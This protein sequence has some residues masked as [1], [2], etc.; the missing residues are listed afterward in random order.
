MAVSKPQSR[1]A[2]FIPDDRQRDAIEHVHGPML[3]VAGA[4]TGKT[5][6]LTNRIAYLVGE[7]H[8][9][10]DEILALTYTKNAA[11]EMRDRVRKLLGGRA[12][13]AATFHDYCLDVLQRSHQ[14]F[15]VLDD[16]DLWIY[17]RRRIRELHLEY[18]VRAANVGQ[19]LTDLLDFVSRCH[20]E[21]VSPDKYSQYV[22]RLERGEVPIPR[23]AKSKNELDDAEVLGRCREIARVFATMERWLEEENLGTFSH[24][25]T[26]AHALLHSDRKGLAE[27]RARARF[28]LVDEF[29]DAN[30]AQIKILARLAG[31]EGNIF[32]VGDPDQA[33]YRFRGA[34]SAAFELF[35]RHFPSSRLVVLEKNRR[36]TTPILRSAFALIDKNPP[37]FA[38]HA[39]GALAYRRTPLQSAREEEAA[40][41][42]NQIS[43]LPVSVVVLTN[44]DAE[45]PDL[46][47]FIRDSK[48]KL[49][50]RWSDFGILY[51]SHFHRDDIVRELAE[52]DIPFV[53]ENMDI[54]D[55]PEARDLLAC[56]IAAVSP[57][58]DV[59]LVRVTALPCF[60]VDPEQLRAV[61]RAIARESREAQV[62]PLASALD[63]LDGGAAVLAALQQTRDEIRR[64]EAK[65][66]A[67]LDIIVR[68]FE[69]NAASPVLQAVLKFVEV[70]EQKKSNRTTSLDELVDY[71]G[72]FREA[73]GVIPL[74]SGAD[75]D[76][77]RLM[78]VHLAKGLE[79]PHVFI[80]R[81]NANS[82]PCGYKETLVG[83]PNELR[84][85]D[86]AAEGDDKTLHNQEERRLFYVAMTRACDSLNIYARQG[87]GKIN[88]NPDGFLRELI[89]DRSL[90]P[91]LKAIP[92]RGAQA[93]LSIFAAVTPSYP[94]ESRTT[95]WLELPVLDGLQSR[96]SASAV[97]TYERCG[98]QFKLERDWRLS[99]KPAA[100]MQYGASMHRVLRTYFDSV[101][102]GR[103]K[104]DEE[105]I[106][107]FRQDL[108]GTRIQEA[109][110]H[111]LYEKQGV[112]QLR[113]LLAS[114]RSQT[115]LQVL[116]TEE[117]FEIRVGETT[118][119]GRFDRIDARP[120]GTVAIVD[121]KTGKAR[122]QENADESLQLS[123]YAIAAREKWG[124]KVGSLIFYNL[125]ENI[126]VFSTR[127]D[128]QLMVARERVEKAAKG[129]AAGEFEP[130]LGI[131]CTFCSYRSLCPAK[132][133]RI[134]NRAVS[135]ALQS[136]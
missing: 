56:L 81:A 17:L 111:E 122:D 134:P 8:A 57:G 27:A 18:F 114:V 107:L 48:K 4:G 129:I 73:G 15:G 126:P 45:G 69:L 82:F 136:N 125:E 117:S 21:L 71:L 10:P 96:L 97:D 70:W 93:N 38:R 32:A 34:S 64:R 44:K 16:K 41:E 29:Q 103:P 131:H 85:P 119:V 65:G 60:N 133:K 76:A 2:P 51:R 132:E 6:V 58:D 118:V 86:S 120:D 33:I 11:M 50:C 109:Y 90:G 46:V 1:S 61:M 95:E 67:A 25:I 37:V 26:R 128:A 30:F 92:A 5:S 31:S 22:E 53:I 112:E 54:S 20:D 105:L 55:T 130:K 49:R 40:R 19:F 52:A 87:R 121:Y 83:F 14:E 100:A 115:A 77:V 36:S 75:E 79:F 78:T 102:L 98:L 94:G 9:R 108:A 13:H 99:A 80:L 88:K 3:V 39:D 106:D 66:R 127:S 47:S 68:L 23:V 24:M 116:H 101:R 62:V 63:R 91:W 123:L 42:G 35:H 113:D 43:S 135:A 28:I 59:S 104:S 74:E 12:A 89:E 110:Q 72:Y 124:Y 84:D 7:G